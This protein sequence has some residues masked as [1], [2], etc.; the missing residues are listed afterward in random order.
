MSQSTSF[1]LKN[2]QNHLLINIY[3]ASFVKDKYM[4]EKDHQYILY[5][6]LC[7]AFFFSAC[8]AISCSYQAWISYFVFFRI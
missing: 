8:R 6:I 7:V 5:L 2:L 1:F 3:L 4:Y